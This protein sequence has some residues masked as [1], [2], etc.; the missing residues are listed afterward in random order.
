MRDRIPWTGFEVLGCLDS[1]AF[2]G[3][4]LGLGS[5]FSLLVTFGFGGLILL[6]L[7][8]GLELLFLFGLCGFRG[9][10]VFPLGILLL[11]ALTFWEEDG[12]GG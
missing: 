4:G 7:V 2:F 5:Y 10:D 1:L 6:G 11:G 8:F 3:L 9:F 12:G